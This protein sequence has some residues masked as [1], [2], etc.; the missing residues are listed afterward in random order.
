[1]TTTNLGPRPSDP[2]KISFARECF[3]ADGER[4]RFVVCLLAPNYPAKFDSREDAEAFARARRATV[5]E[6]RSI[7]W[8]RVRWF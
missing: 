6:S 1:M 8:K 4:V 2:S 5:T 3:V 7:I